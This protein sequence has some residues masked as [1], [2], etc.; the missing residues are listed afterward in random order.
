MAKAMA[1]AKRH[2]IKGPG[3]RPFALSVIA[4]AITKRG[5]PPG[6]A[7]FALRVGRCP[8]ADQRNQSI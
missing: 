4:S 8:L 7:L 3:Q 1:E 2:L 5:P 6:T